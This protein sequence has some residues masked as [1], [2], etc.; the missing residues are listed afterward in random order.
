MEVTMVSNATRPQI[1]KFRW[2]CAFTALMG[3]L[4]LTGCSGCTSNAAV[5]GIAD[6]VGKQIGTAE[7][8]ISKVGKLKKKAY[9]PYG[10]AYV[11]DLTGATITDQTFDQLAQ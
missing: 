1:F 3:V 8:E 2:L 4:S 7:E 9:P 10:E 5:D 11:V 6:Q